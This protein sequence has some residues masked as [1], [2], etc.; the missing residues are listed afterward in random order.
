MRFTMLSCFSCC[1]Q[2]NLVSEE[3]WRASSGSQH[4]LR[5]RT[6]RKAVLRTCSSSSDSLNFLIATIC[7]AGDL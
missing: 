4:T 3:T 7:E 1:G 5:M 2:G 6:S